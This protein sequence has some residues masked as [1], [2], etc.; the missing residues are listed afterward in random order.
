[1]AAVVASRSLLM[2]ASLAYFSMELQT[3]DSIIQVNEV[4]HRL[5]RELLLIIR[6]HLILILTHNLITQSTSAL[7]RYESYLCR[8]LCP[9]CVRYNTDI[10]GHDIWQ[11]EGPCACAALRRPQSSMS[12]PRRFSDRYQ[13]LEHYL[14]RKSIRLAR[15]CSSLSR[16]SS[17]IIWDLVAEAVRDFDCQIIM[18]R[19][20]GLL[21]GD[22][23]STGGTSFTDVL[24]VPLS[25][26][27]EVPGSELDQDEAWEKRVA[28]SRIQAG[29]GLGCDYHDPCCSPHRGRSCRVG[30]SKPGSGEVREQLLRRTISGVVSLPLTFMTFVFTI[31][32]CFSSKSSTIRVL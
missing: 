17:G 1:M 12:I 19:G 6:S 15:R 14:S 22:C 30:T 5:P 27:R 8:F 24:V 29:L 13:W 21:N 3:L 32:V 2:H 20:R 28:L 25:S 10:Y 7:R 9:E 18:Q 31:L 4:P 11:W 23:S 16:T 26:A